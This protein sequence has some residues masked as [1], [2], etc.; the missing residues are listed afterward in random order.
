MSVPQTAQDL[1][2]GFEDEQKSVVFTALSDYLQLSLFADVAL[3]CGSSAGPAAERR[4]WAHRVVLASSSKFFRDL[5]RQ[6]HSE[7]EKDECSVTVNNCSPT[8]LSYFCRFAR[9]GSGQGACPE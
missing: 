3:V 2:N 7:E 8:N 5:F 9:G 6:D 1:I 4:L